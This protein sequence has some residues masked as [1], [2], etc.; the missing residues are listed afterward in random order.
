M[1][2]TLTAFVVFGC[3]VGAVLLGRILRRLLPEDHLTADSRDTIK[4]AM[5]LVAT[6]T[7]LVLGLL[8]SSAKGAYDTK[9]SEV[10]Q[11]A[12]KVALLD[13]VLRFYG[14]EAAEAR[15]GFHEAVEEAV[16]GMW[17]EEAGVPP[18]LAPN[19]QAGNVVF[20]AIEALSPQDDAQRKRKE[21]ATTLAT[22]FAQLRS[23]LVAQSVASISEPMLIILVSWLAIIFLGFSVLAPPNATVIVALM[24][25]ALA[26]SGAIFLILELDQ[27]FGGLIRI[28]S[29]P[30]LNALHQLATM[31]S[32]GV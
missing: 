29:E 23:L 18:H 20:N 32:V 5:G 16:R 14:P 8:V 1:N 15:A 7:A 6:M 21:Q 17:P 27:P 2:T 12:A 11:M 30:M 24:I 9:R 26:V 31:T 10:I 25:S 4:L 3:L 22:D 19:A 28:S 13:R